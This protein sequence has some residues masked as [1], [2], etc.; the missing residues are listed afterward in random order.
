MLFCSLLDIPT[1]FQC[2]FF[3]LPS[4]PFFFLTISARALYLESGYLT[5]RDFNFIY[6]FIYGCVGSSFLCEDFLQLWQVGATL[7]RSARAFH[8]WPLLL[9]S[10]GS[11]RAG[12]AIVAHGPSRSVACGIL[13]DQGS[14]PCPLHWQADSQP[15]HHQGSPLIG[16]LNR[17]IE[18]ELCRIFPLTRK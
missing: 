1:F 4:L 14:N 11:R 17:D 3:L 8:Y 16:I 18:N 6:L 15:L 12:S 7:H 9:R 5:H 13:P 2:S 10:T